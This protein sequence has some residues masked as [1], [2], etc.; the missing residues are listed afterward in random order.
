MLRYFCEIAYDGTHYHGWQI[1]PNAPTVQEAINNCFSV[2]LKM[3]NFNSQGCGRTDTGVHASQYFFHFDSEV[4]VDIQ[5]LIKKANKILDRA[6]VLKSIFKVH[7]EL[8]ARFSAISRRYHYY[9]S[10]TNN[11]FER[12]YVNQISQK[13]DINKMN[14]AAQLLLNYKDFTSFSKSKTQTNTND[15]IVYEAKWYVENE[16]IIFTIKANRF[17]RNM[18]R[19]IV[20]TLLKVGEGKMSLKEL[21]VIIEAKDRTLAGKSVSGHALF[22]SEVSY[23]VGF[24]M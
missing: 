12:C 9:I 1:Q 19:A 8:H 13:L 4:E 24:K 23:P 6:I 14:E 2:I 5:D 7:K 16:K 20:G 17:L 22:L 3:P 18:V 21:T 10:N 11:P 15:C